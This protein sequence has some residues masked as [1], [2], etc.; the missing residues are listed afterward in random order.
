MRSCVGDLPELL[1]ALAL[2]LV[3]A[4]L[5]ALQGLA[6]GGEGL[7]HRAIALGAQ[8]LLAALDA[9]ALGSVART[10]FGGLEGVSE[11]RRLG[12]R[13]SGVGLGTRRAR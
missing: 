6:H 1:C 3:D 11:G 9:I 4:L 7:H 13:A 5:H 10:L 8:S 12:A 2:H